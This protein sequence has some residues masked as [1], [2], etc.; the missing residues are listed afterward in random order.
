MTLLDEEEEEADI[1]NEDG[2]PWEEEELTL[3]E[4]EELEQENSTGN[5]AHTFDPNDDGVDNYFDEKYFDE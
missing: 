3:E 1:L 2:A 5:K 4:L